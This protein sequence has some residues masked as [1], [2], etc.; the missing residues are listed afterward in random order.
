MAG[1]RKVSVMSEKDISYNDALGYAFDYYIE[2][3]LEHLHQFTV[4][5]GKWNIGYIK[6]F[7]LNK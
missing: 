7:K 2:H 4:Q 1:L 6:M 5:N 3:E